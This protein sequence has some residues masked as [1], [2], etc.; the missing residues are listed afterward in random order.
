LLFEQIVFKKYTK[1]VTKNPISAIESSI[2]LS[3]EDVGQAWDKAGTNV[4][5]KTSRAIFEKKRGTV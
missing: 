5:Q 4:G 3:Q 2:S 1:T